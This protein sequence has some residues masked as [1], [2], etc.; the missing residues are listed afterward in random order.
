MQ[1]KKTIFCAAILFISGLSVHPQQNRSSVHF[2]KTQHNLG[3]VNEED[4]VI[5]HDFIFTN[6]GEDPLVVTDVRAGG[7]ISVVGWTKSPVL[8]GEPGTVTVEF[9]PGNLSGRFNRSIMVSC[10]GSPSNLVLRLLGEV[11][12]RERR[13]EELYPHEA[14]SLRLRS[15]HISFGQVAP[16]SVRTD[17]VGVINLSGE[18]LEIS[19]AAVPEHVALRA[20][21]E[22]LKPGEKGLLIATLDA[23][24]IDDWG[25]ITSYFRILINGLSRGRSIIY[26]TANIQEDFSGMSDTEKQMAPGIRFENHVFDF[27]RIKHGESIGHNFVFTN[28]GRSDLIIRRVRAGCGCTAI[29]PQKTLLKPGES[30]SIRAVF[31]SRG[32]RGRQS[33]SITVISNDPIHPSILLRITG[34]VIE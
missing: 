13:P 3:L 23:G 11:I 32:F 30:S 14:G 31:N 21:P 18:D 25:V 4:G 10:T 28:T 1:L 24:K 12:P 15:N 9:N 20:M 16:G 5:L 29:E 26:L 22:R 6:R 27:G 2:E 34:E 8:P 33:K 19:F 17:S 7:G